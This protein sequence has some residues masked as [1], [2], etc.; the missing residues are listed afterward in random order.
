MECVYNSTYSIECVLWMLND[1]VGNFC[2]G[3]LVIWPIA[4]LHQQGFEY[5]VDHSESPI[6]WRR[7][8]TIL[9]SGV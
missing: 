8:P 6:C 7:Q 1:P 2:V 4:Q 9:S 3:R 5:T